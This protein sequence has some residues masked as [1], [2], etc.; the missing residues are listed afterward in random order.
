MSIAANLIW[1]GLALT[2][3]LALV[4]LAGRLARVRGL[5][6]DPRPARLVPLATLR[7]DTRRRLHLIECDG[8]AVLLLTGR[9]EAMITLDRAP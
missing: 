4:L 1:A 9:G 6:A 8:R 3:V 2:I 5:T 7:V